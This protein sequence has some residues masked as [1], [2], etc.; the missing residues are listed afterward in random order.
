MPLSTSFSGPYYTG[1][2]LSAE[3]PGVFP[4]GIDGR[5]YLLDLNSNQFKRQSIP[6]LRAQADQGSRPTEASLNPDD[7]WRRVMETW[8]KGSGQRY[9]DRDDSDSARFYQS[10]NVDVWTKWQLTLLPAVKQIEVAT[11]TN[12]FLVA[13]GTRYYEC[14]GQVL[15]FATSI[16]VPSFTTVTGTPAANITSITSDGHFIYTAFG[17]SGIYKSNKTISTAASWITGTV[18]GPIAFV[19]GRLMA[20]NLNSIYNIT[21][22]PTAA[23]PF[24]L[25]AALKTQANS[26]FVWV[27]FAEGQGVIYAAGFS[28]D[29]SLIY[30]TTIKPDGTALDEP[31]VRGEL[32]DGEIIRAIQGYLGFVVVGTD[33]GVRFATADGQGN[34]TLGP[35]IRTAKCECFEPQDRFVWFGWNG[36][37]AVVSSGLGRMDLSTFTGP[38]TP[39]YTADLRAGSDT[40]SIVTGAVVSCITFFEGGVDYRIFGVAGAGVY[41]QDTKKCVNGTIDSGQI[42]YGIFDKKF[43]MFLDVRMNPM[44]TP[45][46]AVSPDAPG[47]EL[48]V[49]AD[50]AAFISLGTH[51]L[52]SST[53][54]VFPVG[55][56]DARKFE[57]RLKINRANTT[58]LA[59]TFFRMTF[60]S[61]PAP[62]RIES[63]MVPLMFYEDLN[64]P[65]GNQRHFDVQDNINFITTIVNDRRLVTY[66]E[67]NATFS[68]LIED[69]EFQP[70]HMTRDGK[71]WNGTMLVRL[72]TVTE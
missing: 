47:F 18:G 26:D 31:V 6:L 11:D 58:T 37:A 66:Q 3:V 19:K 29:K 70:H 35:L 2:G 48:F 1:G 71:T 44:L 65:Q 40:A 5:S 14:E 51:S 39:A 25:P 63:F 68:V 22:D 13:A 33:Q 49:S 30:G 41:A 9:F 53:G 28:G 8:H 17:A 52:V 24:A 64:L 10:E 50:D 62:R 20:A 27:G 61:Y 45:N 60:R 55:Q 57:F 42:T 56:R 69:Y 12:L 36:T 34:L 72:K 46:T 38:L 21:S 67:P 15:R 54:F 7:L 43:G 16:A 23:G 4:I 59:D 32:P